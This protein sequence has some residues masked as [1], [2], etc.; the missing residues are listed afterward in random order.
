MYLDATLVATSSASN[1]NSPNP[2]RH[3]IHYTP[4]DDYGNTLANNLWVGAAVETSY[5]NS[6]VNSSTGNTVQ[7]GFQLSRT[8]QGPCSCS[9]SNFKLWNRAL[10]SDEI[11]FLTNQKSGSLTPY[12]G[13]I[14]YE[15][16]LAIITNPSSSYREVPKACNMWLS[17]NNSITEHEYL[18]NIDKEEFNVSTNPSLLADQITKEFKPMVSSSAFTPYITTVGLYN[19]HNELLVIGKL[20]QPLKKTKKYDINIVVRFD[21]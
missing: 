21:T 8:I 7:R 19:N 1:P 12:V 16:G 3:A 17:N 15:N 5:V 18:C 11:T 6:Q 9:I 20:G 10:N 14:F 13:N 4:V 2:I